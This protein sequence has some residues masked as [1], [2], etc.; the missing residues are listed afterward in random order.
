MQ[1]V[2][3]ERGDYPILERS[4][5]IEIQEIRELLLC[6]FACMFDLV[7]MN[8]ARKG[9]NSTSNESIANAMELIELT[10]K[11]DIGR[12]FNHLFETTSIQH[13]CDSLR[14]LVR[15]I[16]FDNVENILSKVLLEQPIRFQ[17][18]TKAV[19]LYMSRKYL[20]DLDR[21]L[22][23]R[24]VEAENK[25]VRETAEYALETR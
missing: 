4:I 13:R 6:L 10:V 1:R 25:M 20:L 5:E 8:Q 3:K 24:Y 15:E 12:H 17:H 7:K 18:W 22:I 23:G 9:L 16:D 14:A 19:S 11:K 2:M 21:Q